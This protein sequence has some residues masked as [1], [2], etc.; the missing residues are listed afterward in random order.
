[1]YNKFNGF[2]TV[3]SER[4][5]WD[6]CGCINIY[7]VTPTKKNLSLRH[8]AHEF[9][10]D[11]CRNDACWVIQKIKH[12]DWQRVDK[13]STIWGHC[14]S[15]MDDEWETEYRGLV[16]RGLM[17]TLVE[18][19]N[20]K[21]T[22]SKSRTSSLGRENVVGDNHDLLAIVETFDQQILIVHGGWII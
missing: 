13:W 3:L 18:P 19:N 17:Y 12:K 22:E 21:L 16:K 8:V 4:S 2:T 14:R 9:I 6:F 15:I 10:L 5:E 20:P 1:M 7:L 11:L